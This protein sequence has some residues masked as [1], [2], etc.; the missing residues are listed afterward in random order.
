MASNPPF[1][2]EHVGS[3]LRP[4]ALKDAAR[5]RAAG[6]LDDATYRATL[7][8][9]VRDAVALQESVGLQLVTDGELGRSSWFG[10]FF[11]R[12]E[13]FTI[14]PSRF[15]FRDAAGGTYEWMTCY[16]SGPM[17]RPRGIATEELERLRGL[18][19]RMPKANLPTPSVLH[20]FRGDECRDPAVYPDMDAWWADLVGIYRAE[21]AD[22]AAHGC[23]YLQLDEVPMAMLCDPDVRDQVAAT[24]ASPDALLATYLAKV[25]E[26]LAGR[27]PELTVAMHLCRG[28]FRSRWMASGGYEPVAE[29]LFAQPGVD[30]FFL[31]YDDERAGD[32]APLRHLPPD[33]VVVLGLVSTKTPVLE[34]ADDLLRRI[35]EASRYV[36]A[37]QLAVSPQCGFASVAGGNS[38]DEDTQRRKLELVVQVAE[39]AWS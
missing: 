29:Q 4:R 25:D 8:A 2:A 38:V 17:R 30:A 10:F 31:E 12:L 14:E 24:G 36:P 35:E 19:T 28:N 21:V 34:D 5:G 32:F 13:G 16:A 9:A 1:R 22:L 20:F 37:H 7:D 39:R 3:L 6:T 26:V 11:E 23:R 33:K 15:R 27:P 18:T